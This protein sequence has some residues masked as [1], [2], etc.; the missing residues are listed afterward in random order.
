MTY[1]KALRDLWT[2]IVIL[3]HGG[4]SAC[5]DENNVFRETEREKRPDDERSRDHC[6]IYCNFKGRTKARRSITPTRH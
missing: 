1:G 5:H 4:K 3:L 6:I 2:A